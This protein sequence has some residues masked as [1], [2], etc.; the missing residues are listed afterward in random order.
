M[1][2]DML[3]LRTIISTVGIVIAANFELCFCGCAR[4]E[5]EINGE[6]CPMCAPG[7]VKHFFYFGFYTV[8]AGIHYTTF[9]PDLQSGE[10]D[11]SC[12]KSDFRQAKLTFVF[13]SFCWRI[14]NLFYI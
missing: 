1:Y 13:L 4:A 6:C 3:L 9:T 14:S 10:V 7:T 8:M 11:A 2:M 5:Y 12:Q